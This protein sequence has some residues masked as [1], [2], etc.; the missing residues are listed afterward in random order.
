MPRSG[1]LDIFFRRGD[2]GRRVPF[3][4]GLEVAGTIRKL[5][6]TGGSH[7]SFLS[8]DGQRLHRCSRHSRRRLNL[9]RPG[10]RVT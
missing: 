2:L 7:R 10:K 5:G 4:P 6:P 3:I 8:R 1:L 9:A